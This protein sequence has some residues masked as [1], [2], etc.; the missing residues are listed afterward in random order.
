MFDEPNENSDF[1]GDDLVSECITDHVTKMPDRPHVVI[2]LSKY[3]DDNEEIRKIG[4]PMSPFK[5]F[6]IDLLALRVY[7]FPLRVFL[8]GFER[9]DQG[10][11]GHFLQAL[12]MLP[13]EEGAIYVDGVARMRIAP[14]KRKPQP[15]PQQ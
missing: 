10:P 12:A 8:F 1:W 2:A 13:I 5:D 7:K 6:F 9:N 15:P 3:T 4:D 11:L 14:V